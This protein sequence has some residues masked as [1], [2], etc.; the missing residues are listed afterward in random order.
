MKGLRTA[1]KN[2]QSG[3][4]ISGHRFEPETHRTGRRI[5]THMAAT[6]VG[7]FGTGQINILLCDQDNFVV[8]LLDACTNVCLNR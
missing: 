6:L 2:L 1:T 5:G 8:E 7:S 4:Q 3:Y